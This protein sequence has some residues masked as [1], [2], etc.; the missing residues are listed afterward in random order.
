MSI[1]NFN[2][3]DTAADHDPVRHH[4][5]LRRENQ[6]DRCKTITRFDEVFREAVVGYGYYTENGN[7]NG[8]GDLARKWEEVVKWGMGKG[9]VVGG[10]GGGG[11][12]GYD[13]GE[14]D[15]ADG[16][17]DVDVDVDMEGGGRG[18]T[19]EVMEK[20]EGDV[21]TEEFGGGG[22]GGGDGGDTLAEG[23]KRVVQ[24]PP[25]HHQHQTPPPPPL[26]PPRL[27]TPRKRSTPTTTTSSLHS[28]PNPYPDIPP[29]LSTIPQP[30]F[31][32]LN[33]HYKHTLTPSSHRLLLRPD[34][35]FDIDKLGLLCTRS[36]RNMVTNP[37]LHKPV[38]GAILPRNVR[39]GKKRRRMEVIVV[40]RGGEGVV[41]AGRKEGKGR[42]GGGGGGGE[43]GKRKEEKIVEKKEV[44]GSTSEKKVK[45]EVPVAGDRRKSLRRGGG[46]KV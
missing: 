18:G 31:L 12:G 44:R 40:D 33:L 1:P 30:P 4:A 26:N 5:R 11:G 28:H 16:N 46:R 6:L 22:G 9:R 19:M 17:I 14:V 27:K 42:G 23:E 41:V 35:D 38:R 36:R 13:G 32:L 20:G 43:K 3:D 45:V 8:C 37:N 34:G 15:V 24:P 39:A 2:D 10:G 25:Q 29:Y 21:Q 7:G